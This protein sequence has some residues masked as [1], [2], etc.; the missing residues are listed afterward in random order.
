MGSHGA[1]TLGAFLVAAN[2]TILIVDDDPE[3]L[4]YFWRLFEVDE[5]VRFD[6]LGDNRPRRHRILCHRLGNSFQLLEMFEA[7]HRSDHRFPLC[8]IDMRMPGADGMIDDRR[9]LAV[10]R[11]V[12][13]IDPEI[14]IVIATA[15]ADIDGDD[16]CREVGG[17]T[18]FFRMPFG[19]AQEEE[20]VFKVHALVDEWNARR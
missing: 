13:E 6:V 19:P 3:K 2:N 20:F 7:M 15:K 9:G 1:T 12:R 11:R 17:S 10:A 14:H 18:H 5:G 16:C 4:A 8:L